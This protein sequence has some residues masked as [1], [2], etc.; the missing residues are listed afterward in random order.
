MSKKALTKKKKIVEGILDEHLS[1]KKIFATN[2]K[3]VFKSD[4]NVA[5]DWIQKEY[6]A[7]FSKF[8]E[9]LELCVE[10]KG[11]D[12]RKSEHN[13]VGSVI[14][15]NGKGKKL[16]IAAFIDDSDESGKKEIIAA[17]ASYAGGESLIEN[18]KNGSCKDFDV[19]IAHPK[20]M[21]K[22]ASELGKI[23]GPRG[24]MPN[25]KM[26]TVANDL[27]SL[28]K[29]IENYAMFRGDKYAR[30]RSVVG[31]TS[32]DQSKIKEN[33]VAFTEN[34][35][36]II[37]TVASIENCYITTTQGNFCFQVEIS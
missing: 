3:G 11:I 32:F 14:L 17:G 8:D 33:L 5:I 37:P 13:I 22:L 2:K 10:L 18:I 12:P 15:P 35:K 6:A 24:L 23:L 20:M 7:K 27:V 29:E 1:S 34:L 28:T 16:K 26:N 19:C 30:V 9:S 4:L 21:A 25:P 31:K 36:K